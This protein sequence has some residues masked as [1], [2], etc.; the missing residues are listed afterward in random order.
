M[1]HIGRAL[2]MTAIVGLGSCGIGVR[3]DVWHPG[4][5]ELV[6]ASSRNGNM[7]IYRRDASG[8][9]QRLTRHDA[10][11][12]W[13]NWAPDGQHIVFQSKR[14][15]N[16]D[17]WLMD[18][19][20]DGLRQLTNDPEPDYLP[21]FSPD[22]KSIV[23]SS[24]RHA[25]GEPRE[26]HVYLMSLDDGATRRLT[27]TTLATSEAARFSPDGGHLIFSR[28]IADGADLFELDLATGVE[29][30]LTFEAT[31][32]HYH[33]APAYS[34]DGR[35]IACYLDGDGHSKIII[36]DADGNNRREIVSEGKNWYPNWS[37]DGQWL[38]FTRQRAGDNGNEIDLAMVS[39]GAERVL[40]G[41][42]AEPGRE[43][44]ASWMTGH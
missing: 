41:I 42:T 44:E 37:P 8:A 24:W 16:L 26:P 22:G 12:N 35:S 25:E 39:V 15:G 28:A 1:N 6:Y 33:G 7:E 17:L 19:N 43:Q 4:R 5:A 9:D 34:P 2:V 31:K 10:G 20:G 38:V 21:S 23:F 30:R 3:N 32:G 14:S 11:D 40:I 18:R 36:I 29:T 13:P 27:N